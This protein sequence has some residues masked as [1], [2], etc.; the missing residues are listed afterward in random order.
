MPDK[1]KRPCGQAG[2][3]QY[4][5]SRE[6][7]CAEH[8]IAHQRRYDA[9]RYAGAQKQYSTT[10]WRMMRKAFLAQH[11][12]CQMCEAKGEY[13]QATIVDHVIP[14]KGDEALFWDS[15]NWAALCKRCHDSKTAASDGGFGNAAAVTDPYTRG[16]G[17][18]RIR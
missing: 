15:N 3:V 18:P 14:H 5:V 17:G 10:R 7:Y 8:A 13:R 16:R 2:C 6:A 4:A 1:P 12:L 11:P 9:D